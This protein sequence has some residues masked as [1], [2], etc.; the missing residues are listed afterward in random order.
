[1][2]YLLDTSIVR[3]IMDERPAVE[4]R[5]TNIASGDLI[6]IPTIVRGEV[7]FGLLQMMPGRKRVAAWSKA[8]E[9]FNEFP[10]VDL[11]ENAWLLYARTKRQTRTEG[12]QLGENDLW[13]AATAFHLDATLVTRD[14]DFGYVDNLRRVDWS[15]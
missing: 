9:I 11:P 12:R 6:R 5:A 7:H 1:M 4:A 8:S 2:I 15:A 3:D 14:N 10:T 13:I